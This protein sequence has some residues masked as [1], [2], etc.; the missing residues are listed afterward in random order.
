MTSVQKI[1]LLLIV[2]NADLAGAPIHVRDLA[3]E[4]HQRGN[5]VSVVFGENGVIKDALDKAGIKTFVLPS[6]RSNINLRQDICSVRE[7]I[8]VVK[9]VRPD[10]IH[11]HSSKAGLIARIVG[12][13]LSIPVIYTVHGW[14]FGRGRRRI[15][16]AFVYLTELML[17]RITSKFISVSNA[18]REIGLK[19][20]AL[21]NSKI[22][23]IYNGSN[24]KSAFRGKDLC[25]LHLIMVARNDHQKDYDTFFKALALSKFDSA[26]IVGRGTNEESFIANAQSLS[27][28]NFKKIQFLGPRSDVEIL[29]ENSTIFVL[30]SRF[31]GLPISII[32]AMS[33]G[34]PVLA[35]AVGGVPELVSNGINGY[36]FNPGEFKDLA[37]RIN[38]LS[39]D[40]RKIELYGEASHARF[41][42]DFSIGSMVDKILNVYLSVMRKDYI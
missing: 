9:A 28:D 41:V 13:Y 31:E 6:I 1:N 17:S 34:M 16:S 29:L 20:F 19:Y 2:T 26:V 23:T 27:G 18:D 40:P 8:R 37:L 15:I 36:L 21:A 5:D 25:G 24:F 7:F 22:S 42:R 39:D 38:D 30:S 35:S 12:F 3:L 11:A 33:K 32:E 14:G 10:V 4:L